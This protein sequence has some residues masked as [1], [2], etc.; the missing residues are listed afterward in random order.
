MENLTQPPT[1]TDPSEFLDDVLGRIWN[2][3]S[4]TF[5]SGGCLPDVKTLFADVD[6][7]KPFQAAKIVLA[8]MLLDAMENVSRFSPWYTR[9]ARAFGLI[10]MLDP[11]DGKKRWML[12]S[13]AILKWSNPLD[14]LTK[15]ID[16]NYSLIRAM[17]LVEDFLEHAEA[18]EPWLLASCACTPPRSIQVTPSI[19]QEGKIICDTCLQPF[20]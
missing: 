17:L 7:S 13:E 9:P 20:G 15:A 16:R 19:L 4:C 1:V 6:L 10:S 11:Y 5:D 3:I 8:H 14:R 2:M 18:G 12:A